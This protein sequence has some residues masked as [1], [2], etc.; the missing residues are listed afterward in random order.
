MR[1]RSVS[2]P[3]GETYEVASLTFEQMESWAKARLEHFGDDPPGKAEEVE[4]T[5]PP[6]AKREWVK[7]GQRIAF[8]FVC[9]SLNRAAGN[10]DWTPERIHKELDPIEWDFLYSEILSF[11]N[12]R[13][14]VQ[15]GES[16]TSSAGEIKKATGEPVAAS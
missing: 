5:Y 11:I 6:D 10:K 1:K 9:Q 16:P 12:L 14:N 3:N 8:D 2:V 7:N 13:A 15:P 4:K